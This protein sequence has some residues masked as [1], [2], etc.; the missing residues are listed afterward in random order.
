[1]KRYIILILTCT[2]AIGVLAAPPKRK[3]NTTPKKHTIERLEKGSFYQVA[4]GGGVSSLQYDLN[5]GNTH[6]YPSLNLQFGYTYYFNKYVG[7]TT[8]LQYTTYTTRA[9]MTDPLLWEG[10]NDYMGDQYTHIT[11]FNDWQERQA[12]HSLELPIALA[13]K[14]KPNKVGL[15]ATLGAKLGIAADQHYI[16]T[17]GSVSHSAYYP[18]WNVTMQDLPNRYETED[19]TGNSQSLSGLHRFNGIGYAEIGTLIELNPHTDLV[20]GAYADVYINNAARFKAAER[21]DLG[22]ATRLNGYSSFMNTYNGLI[23]STQAGSVIR[24]W[25]AGLKI[26][27]SI[28]PQRTDKEKERKAKQ[29][30]RQ[31]KKYLPECPR[32]TVFIPTDSAL[33]CEPCMRQRYATHDTIILHDTIYINSPQQEEPKQYSQ[34][35]KQQSQQLDSLLQSAIIWFHFDEYVPILQPA[36]IL[37]SVAAMLLNNP[38]LRVHVNGH[39][40][41]IG[42]DS[43]NQRLALKRA[44]AVA[45]LLKKKGVKQEQLIVASFGA[46]EPFRYNGKHQ[47]STDRRVEIIPEIYGKDIKVLEPQK[48]GVSSLYT[49]FIGE[50]KVVEG[51]HLS[52]LARKWYNHR[53]YWVYIYEANADRIDNPNDLPV[54]I[55]IMIPDL[56]ASIADSSENEM[57]RRARQLE[58]VYRKQ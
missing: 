33:L 1:M 46:T 4:I 31:Y 15:Y 45:E 23:G 5:G 36:Y 55:T 6:L 40:C 14:Y 35:T 52:Q 34:L 8:G 38:E 47:L 50:E 56:K 25:S 10:L 22:F 7:I 20:I 19:Y 24:P 41:A 28:T 57:L 9:V 21:Q 54:G 26:G 53:E 16:N 18:L 49:K 48:E 58:S 11:R 37:D 17:R 2:L 29:L 44:Q 39:A 42:S 12:I 13:I 51:M 3:K 43:Y 27:I 32:D 30:Y